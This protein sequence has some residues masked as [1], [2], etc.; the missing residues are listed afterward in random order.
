M[1]SAGKNFGPFFLLLFS[2]RSPSV[3][4]RSLGE[5]P[6]PRSPAQPRPRGVLWRRRSG[7]LSPGGLGGEFLTTNTAGSSLSSAGESQGVARVGWE[8]AQWKLLEMSR[9]ASRSY[10]FVEWRSVKAQRRKWAEK[11]HF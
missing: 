6:V 1:P 11:S 3:P 8:G 5:K 10:S 4:S 7:S 9:S 2:S